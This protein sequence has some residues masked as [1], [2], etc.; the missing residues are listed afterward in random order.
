MMQMKTQKNR[1]AKIILY[2]HL[3]AKIDNVLIISTLAILRFF[4]NVLGQKVKDEYT[5]KTMKL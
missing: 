3:M 5:Y 2:G 1:F 4:A